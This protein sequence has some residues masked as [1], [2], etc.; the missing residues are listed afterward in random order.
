MFAW[1]FFVAVFASRVPSLWQLIPYLHAIDCPFDRGPWFVTSRW[2]RFLYFGDS[3]SNGYLGVRN[4][5]NTLGRQIG[6]ILFVR[7]KVVCEVRLLD[8][9][10]AYIALS[11]ESLDSRF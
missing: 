6:V 2:H 11:V 1:S 9:L 8:A 3:L 4:Y 5:S 10:D 7:E